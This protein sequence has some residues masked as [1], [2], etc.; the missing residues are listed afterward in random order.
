MSHHILSSAANTSP[1]I[2]SLINGYD[3]LGTTITS[4]PPMYSNTNGTANSINYP[5]PYKADPAFKMELYKSENGGFVMHLI[6]TDPKTNTD[7]VRMYILPD[8]ENLGR[9]IQNILIMDILKS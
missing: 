5:K 3:P 2:N 9:D 4:I 7:N 6:T 8:I 1:L